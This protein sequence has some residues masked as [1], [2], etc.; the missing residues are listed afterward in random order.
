MKSIVW[1]TAQDMCMLCFFKGLVQTSM[2]LRQTVNLFINL[3]LVF[4]TS[5]LKPLFQ[6]PN[7][8]PKV[9]EFWRCFCEEFLGE[10]SLFLINFWDSQ[11]SWCWLHDLYMLSI[12]L[13]GLHTLFYSVYFLLWKLHDNSSFNYKPIRQV[14][15]NTSTLWSYTLLAS[16][17]VLHCVFRQAVL[18]IS[19]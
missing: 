18:I 11:W 1:S 3:E 14:I 10:V 6:D 16:I 12:D 7:S 15:D 2:K 17:Q 5:G 19:A 13:E 9:P 4:K 8:H